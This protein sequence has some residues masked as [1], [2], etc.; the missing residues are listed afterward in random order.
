M[1][2]K[3]VCIC[4]VLVV[5][6]VLVGCDGGGDEPS[7][8]EYRTGSRALEVTF[9]DGFPSQVYENDDDI[10][11]PVQIENYGAFPQFEELGDLEAFIWVGG[12]ES[13]I[14]QATFDGGDIRKALDPEE[15]EGKSAYN[16][17]GGRTIESLIISIGDL[18]DGTAVYDPRLIFSL[19]YKY[20][21]TASEEIC[22]DTQPRSVEVRDKVCSLSN[23][24]KSYS[25]APQGGPVGVTNVEETVT[26]AQ[27]SFKIDIQNLGS[28]VVIDRALVSDN[29]N[30]GYDWRE[31]NKVY[32]E[33]VQ[34]GGRTVDSCRPPL[35]DPIELYNGQGN[36]ICT[37]SHASA[38]TDEAYITPLT[39]KLE[40]GYKTSDFR[41]IKILEAIET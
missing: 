23:F 37:F 33:D 6:S 17:Q 36:I 31:I 20:R 14:M 40:Y 21:S 39:V 41:N 24:R 22:I 8:I 1:N 28:G 32:V 18:P 35:G 27:T 15:L 13:S 34:V 30:E 38:G 16:L 29:P 4:I 19:T 10:R 9:L 12:Y 25:V 7:V 26:S 2:Q 11:I 3:R 5:L